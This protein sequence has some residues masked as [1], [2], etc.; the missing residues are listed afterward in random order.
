MPPPLLDEQ[1]FEQVGGSNEAAMRDRQS[2]VR[3][4]R[5]EIVL[6]TGKRA[7][8]EVGAVGAAAGRQGLWEAHSRQSLDPPGFTLKLG[9]KDVDLALAAGSELAVPLPL[10]SL[11]RDHF[12]EAIAQGFGAKVWVAMAEIIAAHSGTKLDAPSDR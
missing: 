10:G 3:D 8:Q 6:E 7:R 5:L 9:L 1:P 12:L 4:A 11:L 2:Q